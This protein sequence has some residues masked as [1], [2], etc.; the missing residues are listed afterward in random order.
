MD[1]TIVIATFGAQHWADLAVARA[2]P[3]ARAQGVEVI[4]EHGDTLHGARNR[5]LAK[6]ST[7]WVIHL[8]ADDEL[9][10]GYVNHLAAGTCDLRAPAVS[11]IRPSGRARPPYVPKVAGHHHACA[12]DCLPDGNWMVVGTLARTALLRDVGGWEPWPI[13]EDW[14]LWLRCYEAGASIEAIPAAIYLAHWRPESRNRHPPMDFKDSVH[15]DIIEAIRP[16]AA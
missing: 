10:P 3:S 8:D 13:Y 11:Y 2:I 12:A 15:R 6:V 9:A 1:V 14:A 16:V 7:E 5:G 4:H